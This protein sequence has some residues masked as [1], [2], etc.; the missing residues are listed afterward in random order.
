MRLT[1]MIV[2][3]IPL[4]RFFVLIVGPKL[5][6]MAAVSIFTYL[7]GLW[8]MVSSLFHVLNP[9]QYRQLYFNTIWEA[10]SYLRAK[11]MVVHYHMIVI[12]GPLS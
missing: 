4:S 8:F 7:T 12:D 1:S 3:K 9:K 6:S 5:R 11:F 10:A 2:A